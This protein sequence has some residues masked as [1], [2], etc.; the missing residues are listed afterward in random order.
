MSQKIFVETVVKFDT[1]GNMMPLSIV[2]SNGKS[3]PI[4][5]VSDVRRASS[6]KSGGMGWRYNITI[7]NKERYLFYDL[8]DKKWFVEGR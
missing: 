5:K 3:Y 2:W 6:Q 1:N 8:C 4:D 7:Q